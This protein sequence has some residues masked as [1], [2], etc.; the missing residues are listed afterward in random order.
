MWRGKYANART[1]AE[2]RKIPEKNSFARWEILF[3]ASEGGEENPINVRLVNGNVG[4]ARARLVQLT[5][6]L[7]VRA[8]LW[9]W[10]LCFFFLR[11]ISPPHNTSRSRSL[12]C[13]RIF[14]DRRFFNTKCWLASLKFE[15]DSNSPHSGK[16]ELTNCTTLICLIH[17]TAARE[18]FFCWWLSKHD[19]W[20]YWTW[21]LAV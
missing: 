1:A 11:D 16:R 21:V 14:L 8:M 17:Q 20:T 4:E 18:N 2:E 3:E 5:L 15:C 13:G 19:K 10:N 12:S 9:F 6:E 7:A